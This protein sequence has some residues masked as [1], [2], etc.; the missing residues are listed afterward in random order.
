MVSGSLI[1]LWDCWVGIG[2][3]NSEMSQI[4]RHF[5]THKYLFLEKLPFWRKT[6]SCSSMFRVQ[7]MYNTSKATKI[8][9]ICQISLSMCWICSWLFPVLVS[10]RIFQLSQ[11][12]SSSLRD[13]LCNMLNFITWIWWHFL[14]LLS[15]H[16]DVWFKTPLWTESKTSPYYYFAK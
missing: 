16:R 8:I 15:M 2:L 1:S 9:C 7:A 14:Q 5:C 4:P 11:H 12:L 10:K 3:W 6:V 13:M